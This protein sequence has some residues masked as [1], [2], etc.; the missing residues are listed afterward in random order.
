MNDMENDLA[1]TEGQ[2]R[3][4]ILEAAWESLSAKETFWRAVQATPNFERD[5]GVRTLA[6]LGRYFTDRGRGVLNL[7]ISGFDW[8]AE[9]LLR[10]IYECAAKLLLLA[11]VD[12]GERTTLLEEFWEVAPEA[13]DRKTA[14]KAAEAESVFPEDHASRDV[15]R[16]LRDDRMV[17]KALNLNKAERR[18]IEGKWSFA[19]IIDR[20]ARIQFGGKEMSEIRSFLHIYGMA[21]HLTHVDHA[22]MDL[23]FDR[24][25]RPLD[26]VVVLRI[27][28]IS[29]IASD[30]STLGTFCAH[31]TAPLA[32]LEGGALAEID[33]ANDTLFEISSGYSAQFSE[34]Q[35]G[36]YDRMFGRDGESAPSTL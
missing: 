23:M 10:T 32:G 20:L 6:C 7:G 12:E 4:R 27:G 29:R 9:I 15:F 33:R 34:S 24:A 13:S 8:E 26:E 36:F 21:S 30:M 19:E 25:T 16:L 18:R 28:H 5:E 14:R 22:A 35:R 17:R 31:V 3:A 2:A 11:L 1:A